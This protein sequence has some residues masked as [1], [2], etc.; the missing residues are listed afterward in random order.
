M[1][2]HSPS[3]SRCSV[4]LAS[5]VSVYKPRPRKRNMGC[6]RVYF[7]RC[8]IRARSCWIFFGA[9]QVF[10][11][12]ACLK[13]PFSRNYLAL[14][15]MC[16]TCTNVYTMKSR[17]VASPPRLFFFLANETVR[18]YGVSVFLRGLLLVFC[19]IRRLDIVWFLVLILCFVSSLSV[20]GGSLLLQDLDCHNSQVAWLCSPSYVC[21][22]W[23]WDVQ[24]ECVALSGR[25]AL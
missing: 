9:F 25:E 8:A 19:V 14:E 4:G 22:F 17:I 24:V 1:T 15:V 5:G 13:S 11:W 20:C 10:E 6:T 16:W 7:G 3:K 18:I 12:L 21:A 23:V 2:C